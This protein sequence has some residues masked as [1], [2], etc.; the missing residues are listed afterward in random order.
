MSDSLQLYG[1]RPTTLPLSMGFSRQEYWSGLLCPSPGDLLDPG[2]EPAF[3]KSPPLVCGFFITSAT[4]KTQEEDLVEIYFFHSRGVW[5]I[6]PRSVWSVCTRSLP[7]V[8]DSWSQEASCP[9]FQYSFA[10]WKSQ[11]LSP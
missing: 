5:L 7:V 10:V 9:T 11:K 3:L 4:W 6:P 8:E 2:I 1:P